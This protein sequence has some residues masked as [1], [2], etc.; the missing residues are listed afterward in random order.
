MFY[1]FGYYEPTNYLFVFLTIVFFVIFIYSLNFW[2]NREETDRTKLN[3]NQIIDYDTNVLGL[4]VPVYTELAKDY[5]PMGGIG[6]KIGLFVVV[7]FFAFFL[8]FK[9]AEKVE[10]ISGAGGDYGYSKF[11]Y[12]Y[13]PA[14]VETGK[15]RVCNHEFYGYEKGWFQRAFDLESPPKISDNFDT[16]NVSFKYL[17]EPYFSMQ[18]T[19]N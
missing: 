2:P 9:G 8:V 19:K 15:K 17:K 14:F 5:K 7:G 4:E 1:C 16:A 10:P 3:D 18:S 12:S 13:S 6:L 11:R